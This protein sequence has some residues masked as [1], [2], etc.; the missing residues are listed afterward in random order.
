P[1]A[2]PRE[3]REQVSDPRVL[4]SMVG[5]EERRKVKETWLITTDP[6]DIYKSL[7]QFLKLGFDRVYIH[8]ASPNEE[9]FLNILGRDILPWMREFYEMLGRPIRPIVE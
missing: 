5:E 6:D 9:R 3:K 7:S 1:T 8:S 4:E 2:I